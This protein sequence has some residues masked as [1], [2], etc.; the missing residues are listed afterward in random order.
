MIANRTSNGVPRQVIMVRMKKYM[1]NIKIYSYIL[2]NNLLYR[3]QFLSNNILPGILLSH[4]TPIFLDRDGKRGFCGSPYLYTY[5]GNAEGKHCKFPFTV[6]FM[7][8][9]HQYRFQQESMWKN[10]WKSDCFCQQR[11]FLK[12]IDS[13][14]LF[15]QQNCS[16][17][18]NGFCYC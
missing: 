7:L 15:L 10:I 3:E 16:G 1:N 14:N 4:T 8:K 11:H 18:I 9:T 13:A 5:G 17:D 12:Y 6:S 2:I